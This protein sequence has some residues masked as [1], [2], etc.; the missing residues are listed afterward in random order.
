MQNKTITSSL[1]RSN[2]NG[3]KSSIN[4]SIDQSNSSIKKHYQTKQNGNNLNHS[5]NQYI[6]SHHQQSTRNSHSN[7]SSTNSTQLP[8]LNQ[9]SILLNPHHQTIPT[10]FT[11]GTPTAMISPFINLHTRLHHQTPPSVQLPYYQTSLYPTLPPSSINGLN[12][13]LTTSNNHHSVT[14]TPMITPHASVGYV[15]LL[16]TLPNQHSTRPT[17]V[18]NKNVSFFAPFHQIFLFDFSTKKVH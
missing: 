15:S 12:H 13:G 3:N 8:Q 5:S 16:S 10:Q 18:T 7:N 1:N 17:H 2:S 11:L 6:Y 9:S 14:M 4:H